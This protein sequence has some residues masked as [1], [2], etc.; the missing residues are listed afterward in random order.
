MAPTIKKIQYPWDLPQK[1]EEYFIEVKPVIIEAMATGDPEEQAAV[2]L[3]APKLVAKEDDPEVY[4]F[5]LPIYYGG[6]LSER[7]FLEKAEEMERRHQRKTLELL[8]KVASETGHTLSEL[9]AAYETGN[10]NLYVDDFAPYLAEFSEL[11]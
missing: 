3:L 7:K 9:S 5:A 1:A 10:Q 11:E 2:V 4:G 6:L 8:Q